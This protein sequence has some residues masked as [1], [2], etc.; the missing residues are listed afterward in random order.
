MLTYVQPAV[1]V[2]RL[3]HIGIASISKD[4]NVVHFNSIMFAPCGF[5]L[6]VTYPN[7]NKDN[8]FLFDYEDQAIDYAKDCDA[9]WNDHD[10][11]DRPVYTVKRNY[12]AH[13]YKPA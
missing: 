4:A 7:G 1:D 10:I 8:L 5:T 9:S 13:A 2:L 6:V 12:P 3:V 11:L